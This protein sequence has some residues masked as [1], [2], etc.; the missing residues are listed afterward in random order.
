[1]CE[2]FLG[3][4]TGGTKTRIGVIARG[5]PARVTASVTQPTNKDDPAA[6]VLETVH[7]AMALLPGDGRFLAAGIC[8]PGPLDL[9]GRRPGFL[10]NLPAWKDYPLGDAFEHRLGVPVVLEH[11]AK[12]AAYGELSFGSGRGFSDFIFVTLGTGIGGDRKSVV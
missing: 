7:A 4:D 10:P 2:F 9:R 1:M 5:D 3:I 6:S 12:A 11:D 8:A